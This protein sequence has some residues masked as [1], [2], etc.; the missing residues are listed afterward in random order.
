MLQEEEE[1]EEEEEEEGG[2]AQEEAEA[3]AE[4]EGAPPA[5]YAN[6]AA[7]L[8][9]LGRLGPCVADCDAAL[10]PRP[11]PAKARSRGGKRGRK[12]AVSA[13]HGVP[14]RLRWKLLVRR[15]EA[16]RGLGRAEAAARDL[17]AA[18]LLLRDDAEAAAVLE[19]L[20]SGLHDAAL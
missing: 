8:L 13:D 20:R 1:G 7:C 19:Q 15:A 6:R 11:A 16:H 5:L 14:E 2:A 18:A 4:G 17:D 12:P 9:R 10:A 3:D